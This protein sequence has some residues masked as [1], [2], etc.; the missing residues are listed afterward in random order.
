[1]LVRRLICVSSLFVDVSILVLVL[2]LLIL[3][4]V[5][6][7]L[8]VLTTVPVLLIEAVPRRKV[9]GWALAQV[10][11]PTTAPALYISFEF[12]LLVLGCVGGVARTR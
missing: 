3:L 12:P 7:L 8:V 5:L 11:V 10:V 1:M 2:I 4:N 6:A 9:C